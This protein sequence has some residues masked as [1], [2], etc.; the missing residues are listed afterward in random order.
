VPGES[1]KT[2]S[3]FGG[4]AAIARFRSRGIATRLTLSGLSSDVY[5][6]HVALYLYH[7]G[8]LKLGTSIW[9]IRSGSV[10]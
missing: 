4:D 2:A 9:L 5:A 1:S 6:F 3:T 10:K 8:N 7:I